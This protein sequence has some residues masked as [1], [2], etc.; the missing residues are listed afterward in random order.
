[1]DILIVAAVSNSYQIV[2]STIWNTFNV[3]IHDVAGQ[4]KMR[5]SD[6]MDLICPYCEGFQGRVVFRIWRGGMGRVPS[7]PE[8]VGELLYRKYSLLVLLLAFLLSHGSK[9]AE[10]VLLD[11]DLAASGLEHALRAVFVEN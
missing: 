3:D 2:K 8:C 5:S 6:N 10:I 4:V 7:W 1:M 11:C 9:K